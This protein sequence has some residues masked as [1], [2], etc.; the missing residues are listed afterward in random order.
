MNP[1][2]GVEMEGPD[3]IVKFASAYVKADMSQYCD[4]KWLACC[5]LLGLLMCVNVCV[6]V[7][8]TAQMGP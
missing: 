4:G 7:S 5:S 2:I 1:K 6:C 3:S 8:D